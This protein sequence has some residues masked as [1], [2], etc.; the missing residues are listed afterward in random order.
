MDKVDHLLKLADEYQVMSVLDLCVKCLR[1]EPKTE[2][3]AV[4]ILY[5]TNASA[6][7]RDSERLDIVREECYS[8]IK[9]MKLKDIMENEDFKSLDHDSSER[10]LVKRAERLERFIEEI[11][12]QMIGLAEFCIFLCLED[13]ESKPILST[14]CP[15]HF[16]PS[17]K[18]SCGLID[19][20]QTC[21]V[22]K[23]MV[24]E[25]VSISKVRKSRNYVEH[26]YGGLKHF[27]QKLISVIQDFKNVHT[28]LY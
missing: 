26:R 25:L 21:S 14:C 13:S 17:N 8:L 23:N 11:Y 7:A 28:S 6:I 9:D 24:H 3:N 10:V 19:R 27:D 16:G 1:D 20:I 15:D 2:E 5:L 4:R 18:P 22:C 12:P